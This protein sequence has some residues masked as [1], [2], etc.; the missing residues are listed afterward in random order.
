MRSPSTYRSLTGPY[1]VEAIGDLVSG[2]VESSAGARRTY[3]AESR[4]DEILDQ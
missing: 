1:R 4:A 2:F 3:L